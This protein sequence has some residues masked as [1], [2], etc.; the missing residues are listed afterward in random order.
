M[1][2]TFNGWKKRG[3]VVASGERGSH[4]NEYGDMLFHVSQTV[5]K[6]RTKRVEVYYD[7]YGRRVRTE[8]YYI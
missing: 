8:S 7:S 5:P 3:R 6:G 1:Y 2:N 4:Y